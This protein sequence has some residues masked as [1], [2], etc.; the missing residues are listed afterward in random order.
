MASAFVVLGVTAIQSGLIALLLLERR[1]RICAQRSLR[2]QVTYDQMLA[3][4][5]TVAVR[6]APGDTSHALEHAIARIGRYSGAGAAE[7]LVHGALT[8]QP[9][10]VVR[11]SREKGSPSSSTQSGVGTVAAVE[12]PLQS[13]AVP[14]GTLTLEG[15]L[16]DRVSSTSSRERLEAAADLL[17]AAIARAGVARML[18]DS[19]GHVV[20]MGRVSMMGQLGAA[21]S[22]EL[23]QP[24]TAIL[25]NAEAGAR[26]LESVPPDVSQAREIFRDIIGDHARAMDVIEHV[27]AL[28]RKEAQASAPV[29]MNDVCRN[30]ATLLQCE[31]E[32]KR[33]AVLF[34]LAG[35]L[36]NV[37]GDGVQLQ[38][39]VINLVLNA[40]ESAAASE[41]ERR[42]VVH[43][44]ARGAE[45]ELVVSDT[46]AGFSSQ[47][48]Q[49]LFESFF[50]TK[51]DGMGMGLTIVQQI[52]AQHG[53]IVRAHNAPGGGAILQVTLPA[54]RVFSGAASAH[55]P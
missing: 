6:H 16:I 12:I 54:E 35:A 9:S 27:R 4:L 55:L 53:G 25:A 28:L 23:R 46:G 3:D 14:V 24:L 45:V 47:V 41:R 7:L 36:P 15:L 2:E 49:H 33:V 13:D 11:W 21:M 18:S 30:A 31:A 8:H 39:V 5:R 32:S 42:V 40:I 1:K 29:S 10:E 51:K 22:H 48:Q 17:A 50:S 26:F 19:R 20:H 34:T 52:V 38:Q 37:I 43:T 44:A